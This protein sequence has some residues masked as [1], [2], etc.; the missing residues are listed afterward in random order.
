M[1]DW[2]IFLIL[3]F[4]SLFTIVNPFSTASIF[5]VIT[6][7]ETKKRRIAMSKKA[8]ITAF[9]SFSPSLSEETTSSGSSG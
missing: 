9:L 4:S 2:A 7:G 5:L 3:A 1:Y 8:V 6:K